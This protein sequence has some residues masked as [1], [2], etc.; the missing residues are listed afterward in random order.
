[1]KK[2]VQQ[3]MLGSITSNQEK[4]IEILSRIK[5]AGYDGL[6]LNRYMIHP[7][8]MF[9]QMLTK[10]AGMPSGNGGKLNWLE[11]MRQSGLSVISLHT[12][13]DSLEK[14][15]DTIIKEAKEFKTNK[16]VITGMYGFDYSNEET[17]H[18]LIERLNRAGKILK[19]AGLSF[20][21]HNHNAELTRVKS[22]QRMYDIL[23]QDTNPEYVN[24]EFDS[25][26]FADAGANPCEWMKLLGTRMKLWHATDRGIK[27]SKM[28]T[29]PILKTD[30]VELGTGNLELEKMKDIAQENGVEV[31]V[32]ESHKNW[33]NKDPMQSIELSAKWL[34]QHME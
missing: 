20:L 4:T 31:V 7:T 10:A 28:S 22:G 16:I 13:L 34:N 26:W 18:E 19:D 8:P 1:M 12:D 27:H 23:V 2:A 6:E 3:I 9:V 32:L 30:S 14:E 5:C 33:I 15:M 17:I 24:F 25:Y 21:Y 29:T 11:L